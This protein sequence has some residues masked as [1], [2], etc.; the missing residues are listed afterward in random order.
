M[1][2]EKL[3][4]KLPSA[5]E[6]EYIY[7]NN[8]KTNDPQNY[9]LHIINDIQIEL[10]RNINERNKMKKIYSKILTIINC[11]DTILTSSSV[12][13][14]A[15]EIGLLSTR[16]KIIKA[17]EIVLGLQI[18]SLGFGVGSL[19][20]KYI[21]KQLQLKVEKHQKI[22]TLAE[23]KLNTIQNHISKAIED[24]KISQE[25]FILISEER[26]KFREMKDKIINNL[27]PPINIEKEVER[28]KLLVT[29][30]L[31]EKVLEVFST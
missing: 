31:K 10:E 6:N 19:I 9:R 12:A 22:I 27:Q 13:M 1:E 15:V 4:P 21:S 5:P 30:D 18:S 17:E 16:E 24:G 20:T 8:I 11:T 2:N 23:S 7:L 26:Q 3:Y 14:G 28:V 25:E 29:S